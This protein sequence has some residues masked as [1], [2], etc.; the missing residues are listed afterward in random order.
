MASPM[1][2]PTGLLVQLLKRQSKPMTIHRHR[3][4]HKPT[5]HERAAQ[6]QNTDDLSGDW[7]VVIVG[8]VALA[9]KIAVP[10]VGALIGAVV[11]LAGPRRHA[12][13]DAKAPFSIANGDATFVGGGT[14]KSRGGMA[15]R[16]SWPMVRLTIAGEGLLIGPT[17]RWIR[18]SVPEIFLKWTDIGLIRITT[19]GIRIERVDAPNSWVLF[20][21]GG[22]KL[23][24][25]LAHYPVTIA[26]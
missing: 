3:P 13:N 12:S 18:W 23:V 15:G 19:T 10:L 16:A 9:F 24:E 4:P 25:T 22:Q 8:S 2:H 7:T 1:A 26:R 6:E 17:S 5:A 11:F 21:L 14:W 20:Q